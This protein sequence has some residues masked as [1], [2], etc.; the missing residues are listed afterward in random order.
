MANIT[1]RELLMAVPGIGL[2]SSALRADGAVRYTEQWTLKMKLYVPRI[3]DNMSS[4]GYRKYQLQ[5]IN[6]VFKVAPVADSEPEISFVWM[7]NATHKVNGRRVTY[8]AEPNGVVLWHGIGNNRTGV[9]KTRS[10]VLPI[11]AMPS[12]AIGPAPTEDNS[13]VVVLSGR[14]SANGKVIR[15]NVAGQLG[16]GCYEYGH[17]SPTRIWGQDRV[18]DTAAVYGSWSAKRTV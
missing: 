13:L 9:F 14:G 16:C 4:R 11:E 18:V 5:T 10:V 7:E 1:R 2:A 15:G 6:G 8:E 12:Y 17:V 3:Y